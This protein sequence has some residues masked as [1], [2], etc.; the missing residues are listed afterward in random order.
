M[1]PPSPPAK[2]PQQRQR[3][4]IPL[5]KPPL[6]RLTEQRSPARRLEQG[7]R[8]PQF[9]R[10][11]R[12]KHTLGAGAAQPLKCGH[13]RP[14]PRPK[15]RMRQI[16]PRLLNRPDPIPPRHL[17]TSKPG[18]L[19]KNE[20]HPVTPLRPTANLGECHVV[21]AGLSI[22]E[23]AEF[24][25]ALIQWTDISTSLI[26]LGKCNVPFT[27]SVRNERRSTIAPLAAK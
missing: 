5:P 26:E 9:H 19:R 22:D 18:K 2:L 25:R 14:K 7:Q 27:C 11:H 6:Q 21:S 3:P 10:I 17:A 4:Q 15:H 24:K 1:P 8:R 16:R 12:P 20:P 13:T 23:S